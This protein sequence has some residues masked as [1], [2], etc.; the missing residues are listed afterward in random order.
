MWIH[1]GF[2]TYVKKLDKI[3]R[4]YSLRMMY[5]KEPCI[6]KYISGVIHRKKKSLTKLLIGEFWI[7]HQLL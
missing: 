5:F 2:L 3:D 7:T 4:K 6:L 1:L